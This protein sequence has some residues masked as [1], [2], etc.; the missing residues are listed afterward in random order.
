[1]G[2]LTDPNTG[3]GVFMRNLTK[4]Q[5][6]LYILLYLGGVAWLLI[7][8]HPKMGNETYF[9]ENALL[10]GLVKTQ[11]SE[12]QTAGNFY[13]ELVEEMDAHEDA[14]PYS[15]L[16]AKFRQMGLET[17][18]HNFSLTYPLNASLT[19]TGKNVYAILHAPRA[20]STEALVLSVPYR[21]PLSIHPPT[22]VSV[23]L[24]LAFAKAAVSKYIFILLRLFLN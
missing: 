5:S 9:S 19:Y 22:A 23:A 6:F 1:M 2:L 11:F 7:L 15:W 21:S 20:P 24:M 14:I 13:R 3:P 4:F 12:S 10:P 8:S 17:Y 16:L 18:T